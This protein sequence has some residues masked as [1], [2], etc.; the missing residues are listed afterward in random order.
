MNR[1]ADKPNTPVWQ[2]LSALRAGGWGK[3]RILDTLKAG[4]LPVRWYPPECPFDWRDS[5]LQIDCTGNTASI[6]VVYPPGI[7]AVGLEDIAIS[8]IE[9]LVPV[10]GRELITPAEKSKA[11]R[12]QKLSPGRG[13]AGAILAKLF[14]DQLPPVDEAPKATLVRAIANNWAILPNPLDIKIP[15]DDTLE[16]AID[17]RR[18]PNTESH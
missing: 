8:E 7:E 15:S 16:R 18:P 12:K 14:P 17:A 13:R 10:D 4:Q 9:I 3:Q 6:S 11:T 5:T 1:A 2:S